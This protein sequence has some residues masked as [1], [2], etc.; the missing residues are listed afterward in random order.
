MSHQNLAEGGLKNSWAHLAESIRADLAELTLA[1]ERLLREGDTDG[2][3]AF[4]ED[5][6]ECKSKIADCEIL[7]KTN[8]P[9]SMPT[10][11]NPARSARK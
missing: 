7:A 8:V 3:A 5:I 4:D 9:F 10:W 2:A 6:A 11:R 1:R